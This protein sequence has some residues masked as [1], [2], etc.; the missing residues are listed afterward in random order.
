MLKTRPKQD[1]SWPSIGNSAICGNI[2]YLATG[3]APLNQ[4][5]GRPELHVS[6][7]KWAEAQKMMARQCKPYP[8]WMALEVWPSIEFHVV[9]VFWSHESSQPQTLRCQTETN[10]SLKLKHLEVQCG[11]ALHLGCDLLLLIGCETWGLP[12]GYPWFFINSPDGISLIQHLRQPWGAANLLKSQRSKRPA[13]WPKYVCSSRS[14]P[15]VRTKTGQSRFPS[16]G[17]QSQQCGTVMES[18]AII[19]I[20]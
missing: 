12:L 2:R 6:P 5:T 14:P 1:R 13:V 17:G 10:P 7:K 9:I 11:F 18:G 3:S 19:V 8:I 16:P 20:Q 4:R 15:S